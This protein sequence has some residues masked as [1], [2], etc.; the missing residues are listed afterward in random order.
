ML[1]KL[2]YIFQNVENKQIHCNN[3]LQLTYYH[4]IVSLNIKQHDAK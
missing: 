4:L 3:I 1:S 2:L